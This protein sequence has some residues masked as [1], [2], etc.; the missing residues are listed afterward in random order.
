LN[1][2]P[3][4]VK[5]FRLFDKVLF[6]NKECFIFGR[7]T[8]GYL[9]LRKLDGIVIHRSAGVKNLKLLEKQ[10]TLLIERKAV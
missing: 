2:A 7:R 9:D 1:Q 4:L 6:Y 10:K 5:G 8:S 3:Y